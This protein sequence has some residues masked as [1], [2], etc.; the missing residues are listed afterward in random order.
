[1]KTAEEKQEFEIGLSIYLPYGLKVEKDGQ[2]YTVVNDHEYALAHSFVLEL[3]DVIN[4]DLKPI[5]RPLSSITDE[6]N[7]EYLE[8][9]LS[10]QNSTE[11]MVKNID[12]LSR[13][14]YDYRG[15]IEKGWAKEEKKN[16]E[17]AG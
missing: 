15:W 6:E 7:K 10:C 1:M 2:E 14:F 3:V 9:L 5:L 4:E 11:R 8:V 16:E 12:Y 17:K 13:N